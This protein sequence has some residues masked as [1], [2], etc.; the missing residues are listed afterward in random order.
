[1]SSRALRRLQQDS[2]EIKVS[3]TVE[4]SSGDEENPAKNSRK[5]NNSGNPFAAVRLA[6]ER[7]LFSGVAIL[8][9]C[10]ENLID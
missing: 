8:R 9:A 3:G 6:V 7:V 1:M 10:W 5:K 4:S 2:A